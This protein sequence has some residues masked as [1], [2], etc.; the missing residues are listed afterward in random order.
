[1]A[2]IEV[3]DIKI[4]KNGAWHSI[5]N[6]AVYKNGKKN[7]LPGM[8]AV[9]KSATNTWY[10]LAAETPSVQSGFFEYGFTIE[11]VDI[12][13]YVHFIDFVLP[14]TTFHIEFTLHLQYGGNYM[15]SVVEVQPGQTEGG[16]FIVGGALV[17]VPNNI[18]L[19]FFTPTQKEDGG[20]I[21]PN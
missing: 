6:G 3:Q 17:E 19:D 12:R 1:M 20:Y 15:H 8:A 21:Y 16:Q 4:R 13:T 2:T 10:K 14:N 7:I 5:K 11:D 18:S 9:Y